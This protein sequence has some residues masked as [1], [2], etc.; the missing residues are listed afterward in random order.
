[1]GESNTMSN[2]KVVG[3]GALNI[4]HLYQVERIIDDGETI[5]DESMSSPGGSAANTIY[6]LAKL[7][8]NAGFIGVI[9]DDAEGKILTQD[10][11]KVGV[12]TSQIKLKHR[13]KTGSVLCLSDK[14][15]S[16]SL[17]VMPGANSLLTMDDLDL[18]YINQAKMF[19]LSSFVNDR[20]F[21]I[22]LDLIDRLDSSVKISFAPGAL[23][24]SRGLKALNP[25]LARTYV[26][27]T[28]RNEI[29]QL[30]G[31]DFNNGA[32]ICLEQGC[33]IVVV[34]LGKGA[35]LESIEGTVHRKVTSICYSQENKR[36]YAI[37][38]DNQH[39]IPEVDTTGAGD[40][41][42]TGFL[43]GLLNGKGLEE[44]GHLGDIAARF[45]IAKVGAR[46]GLPTSTELTQCYQELHNKEF[47]P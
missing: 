43:Y 10:F 23:Y 2:F 13:A 21:K 6:G 40:A 1:M 46:Q 28:N 18:G 26:L 31:E 33:H 32:R 12:D 37:K 27:F 8:V 38:A 30:T 39:T 15:N 3:L 16:R 45:S 9:G 17:Y 34:T 20:Q 25:V 42:A 19:H 36:G 4:D 11:Q 22:S 41:F 35:E 7:D 5:V 44:C 29:R 14:R 24:T 47:R